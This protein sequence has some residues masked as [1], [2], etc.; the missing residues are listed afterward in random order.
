MCSQSGKKERPIT[1]PRQ[2]FPRSK[3]DPKTYQAMKA[4]PAN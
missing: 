3:A 1:K 2:L 4:T